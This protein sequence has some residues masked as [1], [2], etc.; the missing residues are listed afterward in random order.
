M[1]TIYYPSTGV[2]TMKASTKAK[3]RERAFIAAVGVVMVGGIVLASVYG[4]NARQERV[5]EAHQSK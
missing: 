5:V 3:W 1:Q 2:K 4:D